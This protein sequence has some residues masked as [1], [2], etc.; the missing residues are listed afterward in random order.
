MKLKHFLSFLGI[1]ALITYIKIFASELSTPKIKKEVI[2]KEDPN[3][4]LIDSLNAES[5]RR[6][7]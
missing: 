3:Q 7:N 6:G 2:L 1:L 5:L 4:A